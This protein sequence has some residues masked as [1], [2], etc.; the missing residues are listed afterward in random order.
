MN[1]LE[2]RKKRYLQDDLPIRLGGLAA[3]LARVNSFVQNSANK[4]SVNSLL[5]ESKHFIEWTAQE[6][7]VKIS[8]ELVDLQIIIARW[9][10]KLDEIWNNETQRLKIGEQAKMLSNKVL[11]NSGLL[12]RN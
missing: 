12:D 3:N 5:Q 11:N 9:Q 1:N 10:L 2:E 7:D 4:E 6:T 8:A